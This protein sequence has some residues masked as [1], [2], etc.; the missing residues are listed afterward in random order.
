MNLHITQQANTDLLI[1]LREILI[2]ISLASAVIASPKTPVIVARVAAVM[3]Q[4][5]AMA[6]AD[7]LAT[8]EDFS[9]VQEAAQ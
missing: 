3:I 5:T 9:V 1:E 2:L 4:H 6:W 7:L 8:T